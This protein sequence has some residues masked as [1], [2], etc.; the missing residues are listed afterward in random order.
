MKAIINGA[1][2]WQIE[3]KGAQLVINGEIQQ[4]DLNHVQ[5]GSYHLILNGVSYEMEVLE[6][7]TANKEFLIKVNGKK[8]AVNLRTKYDELLKELGMDSSAALR[9]G[10]LKAPMPGLVVNIPV[11]EG[12]SILKGDTLLVLEAMKMENSLKASADATVKKI[13]VKKGQ[14]VEKNEVLIYLS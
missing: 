9:V 7:D 14:A 11:E 10:D 13:V 1:A 8:V 3:N 2:E 4:F 5:S 12:Q 6:S